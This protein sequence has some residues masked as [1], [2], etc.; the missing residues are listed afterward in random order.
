LDSS[1][2]DGQMAHA[3]ERMIGLIASL[4]GLDVG[5][6]DL[7]GREGN[8]VPILVGS[9]QNLIVQ[10]E[11]ADYLARQGKLMRGLYTVV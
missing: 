9:A 7:A 1:H 10:E 11:P 8:D 5:L 2:N 4:E 6:V 3:L